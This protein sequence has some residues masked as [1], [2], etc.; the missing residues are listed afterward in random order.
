MMMSMTRYR[1]IPLM[2]TAAVA[3]A[4]AQ[5]LKPANTLDI[6]V[7]D[8]EG[9]NAT[10]FI[11]PSGESVLI[12]TGNVGPAAIRDA[13]RIAAAAKDAGITRIDTLITTH[14]HG[15]HFGGMAELAKLLPIRRFVDHGA[16]VQPAAAADDFLQ[17]VYPTLYKATEHSI[18]KAGDRIPVSGIDW[19]IVSA[20]GKTIT[21]PLAG[22]GA[23]NPYCAG[24]KAHTVNPVSGQPVGNTEDEQSV[25]SNITFGKFR[26][27][28]LGD[29][30]WNKEFEL[31]CPNNRLGAVDL[32]IVSR[33]GQPSSNSE[34][35]VHAI[36]PKVAIINNAARKGGQGET[37]RVLYSSPGIEGIW[38]IHYSVLGGR[39][40]AVPGLFIANVGE[41]TPHDGAAYWIKVSA[42]P[43]GHFTVTNNRN[44]FSRS[45]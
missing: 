22:A 20:G 44:G 15:D 4:A 31:M 26:V 2:L 25:S 23:P 12:D 1:A 32:F 28:H 27:A 34:T 5:T 6:Y 21:A 42:Q 7:V 35:L 37:M 38:Q 30:T 39:E 14:W 11:A 3:I 43:D 18:A 33:H 29:L 8:V 10:L 19:R 41:D 24:F 45:Y 13:G 17:G 40:Y 9:G 16:N 36:R